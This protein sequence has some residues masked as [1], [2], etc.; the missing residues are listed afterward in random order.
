MRLRPIVFGLLLLAFLVSAPSRPS[1]ATIQARLPFYLSGGA[2]LTVSAVSTNTTA[3][4]G[5]AYAV[6]AS[7][8]AVTITLPS[9]GGSASC[10]IVVKKVDSSANAV[11]IA[12]AGSDLIDGLTSQTINAQYAA[13]SL[14]DD[15]TSNWF[16]R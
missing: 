8:G 4:C 3:V 7:G 12:R 10:E 9:A 11:T 1:E 5:T 2:W 15:G 14:L 13:Y 6:T 16:I